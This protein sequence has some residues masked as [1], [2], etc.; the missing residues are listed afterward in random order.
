MSGPTTTMI[1]APSVN[2][3]MTKTSTTIAVTDAEVALIAT[4]RRHWP[5]RSR[6]CRAT[7]PA[8]ARV[9]PVNTPMA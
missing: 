6:R 1:H 9:K 5:V 8:P 7:I 4:P 3:A 2:L